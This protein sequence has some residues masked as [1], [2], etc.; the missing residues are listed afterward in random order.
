MDPPIEFAKLSGSGNDFAC[1]DNRDGRFEELVGSPE[2]IGPFAR[3]LCRRHMGI[4]ADGVIFAS[5]S[6]VPEM[7]DVGARFFEADG[8]ETDLCGNGT[9]CFARW[10]FD[11]GFVA[12]R[13]IRI[14]TPAG[15]VLAECAD[16]N[17]VTVCIPSPEQ[18]QRG[19]EVT[20]DGFPL[21]CD[22]VVT[23]VPH[24]ATYVDDVEKLDMARLGPALR[25]H[26]RFAPQGV[27]ANFVQVLG[28]GEIAV[29]TWEYGVEGETL[30]CGTGS[31]SA[32]ILAAMRFDWP[33]E[34]RSHDKPVLVHARSG[35]VLRVYFAEKADGT[36]DDV[37]LE[38]IVR[39]LYSGTISP[40]LAAAALAGVD[41]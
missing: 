30:A 40:E 33:A 6:E 18:S 21:L 3:R 8:S 1:I 16:G 32:A 41:A 24:L 7:A 25:Y 12:H 34:Y 19:L 11:N 31:A 4:G 9:A 17:Y 23:G 13:E 39:F 28:P 38:T 35:D 36:V 27:N 15:V 37:C 2:R 5:R 26:Q 22:Y 29:R 14:L 10:A 20:V